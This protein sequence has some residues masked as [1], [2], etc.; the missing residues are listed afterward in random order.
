MT[1]RVA[2]IAD[3]HFDES[4]RWEECCRVHD[5][6]AAEVV[7]R[8]VDVVCLSGDLFE[9]KSTPRE[10]NHVAAWL[11]GLARYAPVVGVYGNHEAQGDLDVFNR[12][13]TMYP[14]TFHSRPATHLVARGGEVLL[15]IACLPWPR[16]AMLAAHL[17]SALPLATVDQAAGDALRGVLRGFGESA[18]AGPRLLLSHAMVR[19]SRTSAGQPLVG[20]DMEIGL[21]DLALARA[22]A[23]ALG[24]VHMP[25]TWDVAVVPELRQPHLDR[26]IPVIYPGSPRRTAFGEVETKGF[27]VLTFGERH[28]SGAMPVEIERVATPCAPMHLVTGNYLVDEPSLNDDGREPW[29]GLAHDGHRLDMRAAEVRFRYLVAADRRDAAKA[30]AEVLR[31]TWLAAGAVHVKIEEEVIAETRARAPEIAAARTIAE[32][33]AAMYRHQGVETERAESLI[34]RARSLEAA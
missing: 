4:S 20:C 19:G 28:E 12:L 27:V 32:K 10:R 21:D 26:S 31:A 8:D 16:K 29:T 6:I 7:R 22:D 14:L 24:H 34:T 17:G 1:L 9:R 2:I 25:Q 18:H 33:L 23:V 5:W 11:C 3:S 30:D 15:E 13:D